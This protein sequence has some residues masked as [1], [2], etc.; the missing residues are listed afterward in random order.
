MTTLDPSVT[1]A[2]YAL[3]ALGVEHASLL[4]TALTAGWMTDAERATLRPLAA[5]VAHLAGLPLNEVTA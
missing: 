4:V 3:A 1:A 2:D 5:G